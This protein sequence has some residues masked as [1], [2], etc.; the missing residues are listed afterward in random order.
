MNDPFR[1][2]PNA[3][4][5]KTGDL[6]RYLATGEVEYLGRIDHQ[7]KIRGFR[8]ELGEIESALSEHP[9][10]RD[11][12]VVAR[13]DAPGAKRLVA[14]LVA[15]SP[16][17]EI[18]AL[19]EHLKQMLPEYMVPSVFVFLEKMPLTISG[20]IDRKALPA[21]EQQRP[22]LGDLYV[23]PRTEA[24]KK[25]AAI[26]SQALRVE[27]VGVNDNFFELGGD[28]ILSI[29]IISLAR[30]EGLKLT[31]KLL[32]AN[33]TIATLAAAA[34]VTEAEQ[35]AGGSAAGEI[36]TG[37]VPLTPIEH[38]FFEQNL[39]DAHHF[40]QAFLFTVTE[41]LDPAV[42]ENALS[43]LSRHHDALRL[44]FERDGQ[45]WR[46]R[47]STEAES[48]PLVWK[49]LSQ[50]SP[51]AWKTEIE[52]TAAAEQASLNLQNG[53]LWRVVY[54][55][56]GAERPDRLLFVVHHLA[57]DGISW[58]PLLE[59]LE[60]AYQQLKSAQKVELP[61]KTASYKVWAER[62]QKFASSESLRAKNCLSGWQPR[63]PQ[64]WNPR[65]KPFSDGHSKRQPPTSRAT[66]RR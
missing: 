43:A 18:S 26:W 25:L 49:D 27:Q 62:L 12:A 63:I 46:Q 44:R 14:Y 34:G 37:E 3:R 40:N 24:E 66:R 58:R 21:P 54:F 52:S 8:I 48:A 61:A 7:V 56:L 23:A 64:Q 53:P 35:T 55:D 11:V 9:G 38:W 41:K 50:V 4:L 16:A 6:A 59:D 39:A 60:T 13:G 2:A 36:V 32:F 45:N 31:P 19:R 57:V 10:V 30:R 29:Q 47:Y 28:S 33:Q 5:Y 22:E 65:M 51:N 15:S 1:D 42:L 17:P 20:K